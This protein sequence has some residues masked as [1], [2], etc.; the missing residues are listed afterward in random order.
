[1]AVGSRNAARMLFELGLADARRHEVGDVVNEMMLYG[2]YRKTHPRYNK[3]PVILRVSR[4]L[5]RR[6]V[7]SGLHHRAA[8]HRIGGPKAA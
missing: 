6:C 8:E 5:Q 1:M 4:R 3:V 7:A 2:F